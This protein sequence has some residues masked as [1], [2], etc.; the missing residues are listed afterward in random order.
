M[1]VFCFDSIQARRKEGDFAFLHPPSPV[2]R[3]L[4]TLMGFCSM[5]LNSQQKRGITASN[6]PPF[7][8]YTRVSCLLDDGV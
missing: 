3:L 4:R 1:S 5:G 7:L 6:A 8:V 2:S